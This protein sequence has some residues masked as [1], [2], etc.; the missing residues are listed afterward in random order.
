MKREEIIAISTYYELIENARERGISLS[1]K[2]NEE[3][4]Y[5]KSKMN[6]K[7]YAFIKENLQD[8]E[9]YLINIMAKF[10]TELEEIRND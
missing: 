9:F 10:L 4:F 2:K 7:E 8:D 6:K 3:E 5:R 1:Y